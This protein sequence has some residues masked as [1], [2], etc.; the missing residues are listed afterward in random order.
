M[1]IKMSLTTLIAAATLAFGGVVI[2]QPT[3]TPGAGC[4]ATANAMRGGNLGG[5]ASDAGCTTAGAKNATAPVA[6][7]VAAT[8]MPAAAPVM[9]TTTTTTTTNSMAVASDNSGAR[10]VRAPMR[11]ARAP[12]ADRN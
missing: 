3:S 7:P 12:R 10:T 8:A 9:A 11:M 6:A 5:S 4:T 1:T 2:A